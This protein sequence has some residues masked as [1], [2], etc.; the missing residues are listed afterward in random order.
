MSSSLE[1]ERTL[2]LLEDGGCADEEP[3]QEAQA[4]LQRRWAAPRRVD[5][6]GLDLGGKEGREGHVGDECG[7]GMVDEGVYLL[8]LFDAGLHLKDTTEQVMEGHARNGRRFLVG[9]ECMLE[10][11]N[12]T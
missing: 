5:G 10:P 4:W 9:S 12:I 2:K 6:D 1:G 8:G 11:P 3:Q 7:A